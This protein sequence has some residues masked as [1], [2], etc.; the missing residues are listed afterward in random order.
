MPR[1][2]PEPPGPYCLEWLAAS[3]TLE[4]RRSYAKALYHDDDATLDDLHE[5]V[6]TLED[7]ERI[8]RRVLG[9]THPTTMGIEDHLRE[10][11]AALRAREGDDVSSICEAVAAMTA[12]DA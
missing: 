10:A 8:A 5:A 11:L 12:G 6:T 1:P 9:G 2:P 7:V 4:L 3:P